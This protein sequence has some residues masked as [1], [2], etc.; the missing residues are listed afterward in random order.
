[1]AEEI[2]EVAE[3]DPCTYGTVK[4]AA[5]WSS[6]I[7]Q[8][9]RIL[10]QCFMAVFIAE[11]GDRTQIAM[12]GVHVSQPIVPVMLGSAAAFG[13]LTLSAVVL[14]MFIGDRKLSESLLKG[15]CAGSF[16]VFAMIAIRDGLAARAHELHSA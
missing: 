12:I 8:L 11:W 5:P 16:A 1:M 7:S 9:R 6:N 3:E 2:G 4:D 14:G 10:F 15:L 13:M